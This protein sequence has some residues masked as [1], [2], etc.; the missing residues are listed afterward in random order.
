MPASAGYISKFDAAST[1]GLWRHKWSSILF[2]LI[3]DDFGIEYVDKC[4]SN[5]LRDILLEY[6]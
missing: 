4:H 2:C 6:Y 5:Y 1:P 3:V